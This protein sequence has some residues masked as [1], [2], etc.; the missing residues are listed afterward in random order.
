[1]QG[2]WS[3]AQNVDR[4]AGGQ[5]DCPAAVPQQLQQG[6]GEDSGILSDQN[7]IGLFYHGND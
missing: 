5:G 4:N 6:A 2:G 3:A 7:S 1:M